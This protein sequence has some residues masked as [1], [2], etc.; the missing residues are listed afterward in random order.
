MSGDLGLE[1]D[2]PDQAM[3]GDQLNSN[4]NLMCVHYKENQSEEE[5][6]YFIN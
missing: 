6:I 3:D 5:E 1:N 2:Q 4:N